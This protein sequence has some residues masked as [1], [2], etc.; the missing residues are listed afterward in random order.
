MFPVSSAELADAAKT[1]QRNRNGV[2]PRLRQD[3]SAV[4]GLDGLDGRLSLP[5]G[6]TLVERAPST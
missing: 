4:G 5:D 3:H 2:R 1:G 6:T